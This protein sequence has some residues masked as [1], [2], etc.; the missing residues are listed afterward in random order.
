MVRVWA[1]G[2]VVWALLE[3]QTVVWALFEFLIVVFLE[4]TDDLFLVVVSTGNMR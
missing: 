2:L 4:G 1:V 3:I